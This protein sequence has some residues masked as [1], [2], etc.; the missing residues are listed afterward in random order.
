MRVQPRLGPKVAAKT[1][2]DHSV[3]TK[4]P[5]MDIEDL[6]EATDH[7]AMARDVL[8]MVIMDLIIMETALRTFFAKH[9]DSSSYQLSLVSLVA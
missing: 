5:S 3:G 2:K 8:I 1:K 9:F 4:G 6:R 7:T